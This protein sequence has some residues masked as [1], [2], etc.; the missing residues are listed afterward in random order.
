MF[1]GTVGDIWKN[2]FRPVLL[3]ESGREEEGI[4]WQ[5]CLV[6]AFR[7][8]PDKEKAF[9]GLESLFDMVRERMKQ[10]EP[11]RRSSKPDSPAGEKPDDPD[12][13]RQGFMEEAA[14]QKEQAAKTVEALTG[15]T[16]FWRMIE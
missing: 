7:R 14:L 11:S 2:S 10:E 5:E 6:Q 4:L 9:G 3:L 15:E 13:L 1:S 12:K 16:D 8:I